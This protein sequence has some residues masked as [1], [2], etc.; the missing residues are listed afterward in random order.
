M[1]ISLFYYHYLLSL[2]LFYSEYG[3]L[4]WGSIGEDI[5]CKS[6]ERYFQTIEI[7][8]PSVTS[9]ETRRKIFTI[10]RTIYFSSSKYDTPKSKS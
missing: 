8:V 3:S 5:F 4:V 10:G 1:G 7:L 9:P 6:G 2:P